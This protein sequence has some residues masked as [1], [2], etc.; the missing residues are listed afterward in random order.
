M[1]HPTPITTTQTDDTGAD[2]HVVGTL[3]H[4]DPTP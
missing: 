2:R 1:T 3:E 4:L